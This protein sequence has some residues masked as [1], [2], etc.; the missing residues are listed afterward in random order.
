MDGRPLRRRLFQA[1][2]RR[3][4]RR[5]QAMTVSGSTIT[6]AV[7]HPCPD[8]RESAQSHR[9]V[10]ASRN[11]PGRVRWSTCSWCRNASTS[12]W[13]AARE[14]RPCSQRQ[15]EGQEHR[16]HRPEAYAPSAAT[17][18]AATRTAY[19]VG[20]GLEALC[21]PDLRVGYARSEV[22]T[23]GTGT[24]DWLEAH[25]SPTPTRSSSPTAKPPT[26]H[27]YPPEVPDVREAT[28]RPRRQP[29]LRDA[30]RDHGGRHRSLLD[31]NSQERQ[32]SQCIVIHDCR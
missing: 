5:C 20:T 30:R 26:R 10:C 9:S 24:S 3:K 1:H 16:H 29:R 18:T 8:A 12:S 11:R 32:W 13:S 28:R 22:L 6:S 15:T 21:V 2:H 17:S 25:G 4:P 31:Q 7:R 14:T 27:S 23:N 19:S